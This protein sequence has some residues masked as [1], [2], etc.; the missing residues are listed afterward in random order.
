MN[1]AKVSIVALILLLT[2]R[3]LN[4]LRIKKAEN[5]GNLNMLDIQ[6]HMVGIVLYK[7]LRKRGLSSIYF[8]GLCRSGQSRALVPLYHNIL[9]SNWTRL[10]S[11]RT[12]VLPNSLHTGSGLCSVLT[13]N[14]KLRGV[15]TK[16]LLIFLFFLADY[17][18]SMA[19]LP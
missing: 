12:T 2:C 6:T 14:Q 7:T 5:I 11:I 9:W 4:C 10:W 1:I 8:A 16:N 19:F 18:S 3:Y 17:H 13:G 15:V